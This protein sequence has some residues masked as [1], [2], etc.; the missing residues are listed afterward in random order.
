V[1]EGRLSVY[2]SRT[3]TRRRSTGADRS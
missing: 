2:L 3:E 1:T